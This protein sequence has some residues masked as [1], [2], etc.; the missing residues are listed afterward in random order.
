MTRKNK[1][2]LMESA[3][4]GA[5]AGLIGGTTLVLAHRALLPRM[6]HT[7]RG[8]VSPWDKR[9]A[10]AADFT[11]LDVSPRTRTAAGI[12]SQLVAAVAV[13]VAYTVISE[14]TEQSRA[15]KQ[16]L[17]AGLVY[18]ASLFAPELEQ[19]RPPRSGRAKLR[20]KALER[21]TAP[22]MYGQATTLALRVLSR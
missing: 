20:R 12:A 11:G 10:R 2:S 8:R 15:G 1:P 5:V 4:R 19:R 9:V 13:G 21:I 14:Q 6:P 22:S 16:L 17:D 18:A 3:A 7:K